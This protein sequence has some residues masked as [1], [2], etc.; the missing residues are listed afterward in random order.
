MAPF[1]ARRAAALLTF[2]LV[3]G[4]ASVAD[5]KWLI[6]P[7]DPSAG[8]YHPPAAGRYCPPIANATANPAIMVAT[9]A[10]YYYG[11]DSGMFC[12]QVDYAK[13]LDL[14]RQAGDSRDV[15]ILLANLK[16]KAKAGDAQAAAV[17]AAS[18]A[19]K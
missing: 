2:A 12:E 18:G 4:A 7:G 3:A 10:E 6:A 1:P 9:A 8:F 19:P 15:A 13:A 17:L 16:A 11:Y 14:L 5:A